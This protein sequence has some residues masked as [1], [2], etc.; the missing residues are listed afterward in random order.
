MTQFFLKST[1]SLAACLSL[2]LAAG[3][4]AGCSN[5]AALQ[6]QVDSL[7]AELNKYKADDA[8][9]KARLATFDTL[10]YDLYSNQK[11]DQFNLSHSDG[12]RV[13]YPDGSTTTGLFPQ[14]IDQLKPMFVFAP[15][16]SINLFK[17]HADRKWQINPPDGAEV[18][19]EH[20]H[21]RALGARWKDDRGILVL[22]Q[23]GVHEADRPGPLMRH[24]RSQPRGL[25][26]R[27]R[28]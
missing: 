7:R 8:L 20:G 28:T 23:P 4:L 1:S 12:I 24:A 17:T 27:G 9:Q 3:A 11:W 26:S 14:H 19:T 2:A 6:A 25:R 21:D 18:Q 5:N 10:D 16:T 15:D 22:G 13:Y